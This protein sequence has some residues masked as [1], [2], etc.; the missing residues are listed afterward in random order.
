MAC[1]VGKEVQLSRYTVPNTK[2]ISHGPK[3]SKWQN[4]DPIP[5]FDNKAQALFTTYYLQ[6]E[7]FS[8]FTFLEIF[9]YQDWDAVDIL[10]N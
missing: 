5:I 3:T 2:R 10:Y 6:A 9:I 8:G 7:F 1:V 4:Q